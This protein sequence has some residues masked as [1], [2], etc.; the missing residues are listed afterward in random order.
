MS[1]SGLAFRQALNNADPDDDD[2]MDKLSTAIAEGT[3]TEIAYYLRHIANR[4]NFPHL[5]SH[6][7]TC[8]V[9]GISGI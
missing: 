7:E 9:F 4:S 2:F 5:V 1:G 3:A 8:T 6:F